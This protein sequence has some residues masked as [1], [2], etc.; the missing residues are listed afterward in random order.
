MKGMIDLQL[1]EFPASLLPRIDRYQQL[2]EE[3]NPG[4]QFSRTA[5]VTSLIARTRRDRSTAPEW[6]TQRLGASPRPTRSGTP[7]IHSTLARR[8]DR[9]GPD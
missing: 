8:S 1:P 7:S 6:A 9:R 3:T 4:V 5:C 2:L